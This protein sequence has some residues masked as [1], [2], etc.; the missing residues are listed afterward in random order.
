ME[1]GEELA[2]IKEKVVDDAIEASEKLDELQS[3]AADIVADA[4]E[5]LAAKE[6]SNTDE[7]VML[8]E[9]DEDDEE[10]LL[11]EIIAEATEIAEE[12]DGVIVLELE[13]GKT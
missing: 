1:A 2:G 9:A 12:K 11:D 5:K 13:E 8:L 6:S 4:G 7:T 10:A 3:D